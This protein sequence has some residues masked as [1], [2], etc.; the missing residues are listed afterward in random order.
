MW[1]MILASVLCSATAFNL[2]QGQPNAQTEDIYIANEHST[3]IGIE[4]FV[5]AYNRNG[6]LMRTV[7]L[8]ETCDQTG[9][10]KAVRTK[11]PDLQFELA[12][13]KL[14]SEGRFDN[15]PFW[16]VL[17]AQA[18]AKGMRVAYGLGYKAGAG[19]VQE[20]TGPGSSICAAAIKSADQLL[21]K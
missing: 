5:A 11:E 9:L 4:M 2:A 1:K 14:I 21:K 17:V 6:L 18:V 20:G 15:V 19:L 7:A 8:L 16:S 3:K 12:T 10:A 13:Q